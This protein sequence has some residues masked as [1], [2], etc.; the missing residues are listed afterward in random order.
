MPSLRVQTGRGRI[1]FP[2]VRKN[3]RERD[4]ARKCTGKSGSGFTN[5]DAEVRFALLL[6]GRR[7]GKIET[8]HASRRSNT[9]RPRQPA[10]SQRIRW[11]CLSPDAVNGTCLRQ[12]IN[13]WDQ[14]PCQARQ[15]CNRSER[16]RQILPGFSN[17]QA[18]RFVLVAD[19]LHADINE[20]DY[21]QHPHP[22]AGHCICCLFCLFEMQM[23]D[24][25]MCSAHPSQVA[26][27]VPAL[28]SRASPG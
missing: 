7:H 3:R 18:L 20:H 2:P 17:R 24:E 27:G 11:R 19:H 26:L 13:G 21:S 12:A 6:T 5:S 23:N 22:P 16:R 28:S 25:G 14:E 9:E 8:M 10:P 4:G 15:D 1:L